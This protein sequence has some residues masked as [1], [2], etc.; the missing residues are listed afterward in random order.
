MK[1]AAL[2]ILMFLSGML[3]SPLFPHNTVEETKPTSVS[4]AEVCD[5]DGEHESTLMFIEYGV[6][7]MKHNEQPMTCVVYSRNNTKQNT[8][9]AAVFKEGTLVYSAISPEMVTSS[10]FQT[11]YASARILSKTVG[12]SK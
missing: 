2:C 3:V 12:V 11:A 7:I 1:F 5:L 4:V 9:A 8:V 6:A 10:Q